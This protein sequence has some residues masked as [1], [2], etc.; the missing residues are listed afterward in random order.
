MTSTFFTIRV[1]AVSGVAETSAVIG[2]AKEGKKI[3][4]IGMISG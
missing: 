2:I 1:K 4:K 3:N